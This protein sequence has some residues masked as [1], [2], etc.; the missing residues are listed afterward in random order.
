MRQPVGTEE[1]L[2]CIQILLSDLTIITHPIEQWEGGGEYLSYLPGE[3]VG[4]RHEI[5]SHRDAIVGL[6]GISG[7]SQIYIWWYNKNMTSDYFVTRE[8]E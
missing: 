3:K 5:E 7:P 8:D 2:V 4:W 1:P 6:S